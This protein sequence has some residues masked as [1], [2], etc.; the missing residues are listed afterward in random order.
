MSNLRLKLAS[1]TS[2]P[3][4]PIVPLPA[5]N[6]AIFNEHGEVLLTRRSQSV[7]EPGKWCLPGGHVELAEKWITAL[8]REVQEETGLVVVQEKLTGIYSD[9]LLTVTNEVLSEGY[10]GQFVVA[11]F[12]V[13]AF[14]GD[15]VPNDEVDEWDWFDVDN[16]P[17]PILKSHPI[18]AQDA[19]RFKGEV[20]VR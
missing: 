1:M 10:Y 20:F 13:V 6:A 14:K 2:P 3:K 5:V 15:V 17:D 9:P 8:R 18:R 11:V 4:A 19:L 16:M 12:K 7:R